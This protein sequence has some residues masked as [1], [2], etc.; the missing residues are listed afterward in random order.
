MTNT[1]DLIALMDAVD[2]SHLDPE[3]AAGHACVT[4]GIRFDQT[5]VYRVPIGATGGHLV[6]S[7]GWITHPHGD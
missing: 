2:W 1:I 5:A 7:C 4:C 3:Q 6:F